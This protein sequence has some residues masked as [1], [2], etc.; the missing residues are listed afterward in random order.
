M[1]LDYNSLEDMSSERNSSSSSSDSSN[2]SL[3]ELEEEMAEVQNR[4]R[5]KKGIRCVYTSR[6]TLFSFQTTMSS[7]P[8]PEQIDFFFEFFLPGK[9][10][11]F[12]KVRVVAFTFCGECNACWPKI[13][14]NFSNICG[15]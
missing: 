5:K 2:S 8:P 7:L 6:N 11:I 9:R 12:K 14:S 13:G 1:E 10:F 15:F 4:V 3:V